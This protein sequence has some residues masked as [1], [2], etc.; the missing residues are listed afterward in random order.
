MGA[1]NS[2]EMVSLGA[3]LAE[4][5][6]QGVLDGVLALAGGDGLAVHLEHIGIGNNA[7]GIADLVH[8]GVL[9]QDGA[10]GGDGGMG[11]QRFIGEIV[12]VAQ[13]FAGGGPARRPARFQTRPGLPR[14][15]R[16]RR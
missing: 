3:V 14:R 12:V 16:I 1:L 15:R 6:H 5:G 10:V 11:A 4:L 9:G 7:V 2:T 8:Q 13:R